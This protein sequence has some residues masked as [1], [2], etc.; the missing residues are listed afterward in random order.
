MTGLDSQHPDLSQQTFHLH[1]AEEIPTVDGITSE[2]CQH[3]KLLGNT[4][5]SWQGPEQSRVLDILDT[6][7]AIN[8]MNL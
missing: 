6:V 3:T 8:N 1:T 2:Q 4:C 7:A 5:C